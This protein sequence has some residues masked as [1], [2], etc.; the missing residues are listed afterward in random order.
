M[1]VH[2]VLFRLKPQLAEAGREG[3]AQALSRA[4]RNIPTIR[5]ARIGARLM[6]GRP[7]EQLMSIDYSFAA[8]LEF[9]DREGL[10]AYLDHDVHDELAQR[11]YASI[12]QALTYDFEMW[13]TDEG[14][15]RIRDAV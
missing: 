3:L 8:I 12:E 4:T 10:Q 11:F 2:V 5:R 15:E 14:T 6:M 7:Y 13:E 9:D 1:I